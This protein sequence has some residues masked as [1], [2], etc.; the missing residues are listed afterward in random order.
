M[1]SACDTGTVISTL[2]GTLPPLGSPSTITSVTGSVWESVVGD[3]TQT[4]PAGTAKT[5]WNMSNTWTYAT[6]SGTTQVPGTSS[7][8]QT[9]SDNDPITGQPI[10][11]TVNPND[12]SSYYS[13]PDGDW[14]AQLS[15]FSAGMAD[16]VSG[17]LTK[18]AR[19]AMGYNDAVN[20]NLRAYGAGQVAGEV[21][22]V[23]VQNLTPCRFVGV[24]RNGVRALHAV[25]G[26]AN[27]MDAGDAFQSGDILS[28]LTSLQAA[29]GSFGKSI[30]N[31]FA[32]GTPV[33]SGGFDSPTD[34]GSFPPAVG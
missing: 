25:Q 6:A 13:P 7:A 18:R 27:L 20:T 31:C 17:G 2:S 33:A 34:S 22:N 29:R 32:A 11:Y 21:I 24:V 30:T 19:T 26:T 3:D 1:F 14:F 23:A 4:G 10:S 28:G 8:T 5:T 9:G 16:T 12:P 15:F